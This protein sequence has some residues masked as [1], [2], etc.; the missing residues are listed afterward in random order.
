MPSPTWS[1]FI[2]DREARYLLANLT[3]ARRCGF[4][5]V[6]SL[7][8]KPPP[9]SFLPRWGRGIYRTGSSGITGG[10]TLR[11]QLEMHLYNGGN[12]LVPGRR[13]WRCAMSAVR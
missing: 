6:S 3:L 8:G 2:K 5:T 13:S 4:K 7:L 9:T 12:G 11:D 10:V 1:F